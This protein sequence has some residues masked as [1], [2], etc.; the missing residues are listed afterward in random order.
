MS[1]N[2]LNLLAVEQSLFILDPPTK[3]FGSCFE[4]NPVSFEMIYQ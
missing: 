4:N 1:R 2:H 3:T